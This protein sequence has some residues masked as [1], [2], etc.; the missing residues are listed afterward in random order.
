[1]SNEFSFLPG[2]VLL[3]PLSERPDLCPGDA[4]EALQVVDR[5]EPLAVAQQ[6]PDAAHGRPVAVRHAQVPQGPQRKGIFL[7]TERT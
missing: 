7:H 6:G 3:R 5:L 2:V 1:M 4:S